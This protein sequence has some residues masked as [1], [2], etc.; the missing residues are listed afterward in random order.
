MYDDEGNLVKVDEDGE[1]KTIGTSEGV[2]DAVTKSANV[3][4]KLLI[5]TR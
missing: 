3:A 1:M 4:E 2:I 5:Q